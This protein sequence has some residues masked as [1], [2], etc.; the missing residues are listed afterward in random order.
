MNKKKQWI[1][2]EEE[3][4]T[5]KKEAKKAKNG[6]EIEILTHSKKERNKKILMVN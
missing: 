3:K 1:W 6:I 5:I 2:N 4:Q